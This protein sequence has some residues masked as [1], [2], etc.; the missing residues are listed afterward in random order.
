MRAERLAERRVDVAVGAEDE[1]PAQP[2]S[3]A[4]NCSSSSDGSSA[5]CRSSSTSTSGR[6][7]RRSAGTAAVA[8]KSRKRAPSDSAGRAPAGREELAQLGQDLRELGRAGA[9]L[10][11]QR[12]R[13]GCRARTRAAT[14]PTASTRARRPPPSSGRRAPRRR[15]PRARV[16]LLGEPALAD[17]RLAGEQEQAPAARERVVEAG[18]ELGELALAP[19]E[20]AASRSSAA[21]SAARAQVERAGPAA[22]I[23]CCE[24]AQAPARLD[25]ELVD[26]RAARVAV[27]LERLGLPPER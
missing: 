26:E 11:A 3:R 1:Q 12:L 5:A 10:R 24:L 4:T 2:S 20:R 13:L 9:E 17:A 23:A 22:R 7:P 14:A 18:G 21:G 27:G 25:A 19:D 8:S 6:S 16:E 15:A